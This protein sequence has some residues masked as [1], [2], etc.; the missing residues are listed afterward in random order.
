MKKIFY[1]TLLFF[2]AFNA[3]ALNYRTPGTGVNWTLDDLVLNSGGNVVFNGIDYIFTDS[4]QIRT[5]DVLRIEQDATVKFNATVLLQVNGS[6]IINPPTGVLFT[7]STPGVYYRGLL[8]ENSAATSFNKLTFEFATTLRVRDCNPVFNNSIFRNNN[9]SSTFGSNTLNLSNANPIITNCQF[10]NNR[11]GAI[12]SGSGIRAAPQIINCTFSGNNSANVNIPHISIVYTGSDTARIIGCTIVNPGGIRT[13]G[14]SV[15]P[16]GAG[17]ANVIIKQNNISNNRY[18]INMLG[19]SLINSIISYN[20]IANNNIENNPNLGGSGI[21]FGGGGAGNHQ[22]SIVTGNTFENNLWGITVLANAGTPPVAVSGSMP[23]LGN[24]NN[25]DTT[26]DGKNR[27]INNNNANTPGVDL[28]NNS[29]D[30]IFAMG[31]YWNTNIESEVEAKIFHLADDATL[32]PVTYTSFILPVK[33]ISFTGSRQGNDVQLQWKTAQETNSHHFDVEK[34][35]DGSNFTIAGIR[36]AA[37]NSATTLTYNFTDVDAGNLGGTIYYRLKQVDIDGS[38]QYSNVLAVTFASTTTRLL[39]SYPTILT[40]G[41]NLTAEMVSAKNQRVKLQ[42]F[43]VNGK[44]L[45]NDQKIVVTGF[46]K[47]DI[48]LPVNASGTVVIKM[49]AEGFNKTISVIIP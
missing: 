38:H 11:R 47:I 46:N 5:G 39:R 48:T 25:A 26:D 45:G 49:N 24:L 3:S 33:L 14:I 28:Y 9:E 22:N 4:V 40:A 41:N 7:T 31:N 35:I 20:Y 32:G 6:L 36:P 12:G 23:N 2:I 21:A 13:G 16:N 34:S 1:V 44:L 17:V 30:P 18:G 42:Y 29:T 8:V 37:G 15:W 10:V 27:F 43:D 19:G